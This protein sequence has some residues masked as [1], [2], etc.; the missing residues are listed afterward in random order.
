MKVLI[1]IL[2]AAG[3]SA[4]GTYIY[5]SNQKAGQFR[6]EL[7]EQQARWKS[8]KDRFETDLKRA[9]TRSGRVETVE[10]RV[11]A[12]TASRG[13]GSAQE[14]IEKLIAIRPGAEGNRNH[15]L[16]QIVYNLESLVEM[17][18]PALPAIRNFL[19]KNQDVEYER[20][21]N[22]GEN[23]AQT[24][25]VTT[26]GPPS[27]GAPAPQSQGASRSGGPNA[28]PRLDF[29]YP[30]S[31]RLGLFNVLGQIRGVDAEQ[32][33]ADVLGTTGRGM[34]LATVAR[35]LEELAPGK[36]K[37][38][39]LQGAKE[40]LTNPPAVDHPTRLDDLSK[41]YLYA[42]LMLYN[43]SSF[44][45]TAQTLLVTPEGRLDRTPLNYLTGVLKDQAVPILYQEYKNSRLTNSTD[46]MN[47]IASTFTY[48]GINPQANDV[49]KEVVMSAVNNLAVSAQKQ[50]PGGGASA[51]TGA[52]ANDS[53]IP[54]MAIARMD[55]GDLNEPEIRSRQQLLMSLKSGIKD[56]KINALID[57]TVQS[58]Q[59]KLT[60]AGARR[61]GSSGTP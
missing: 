58:L 32:A 13:S 28:L 2:V 45:S 19:A 12:P 24:G 16:R 1:S 35:L 3:I 50:S 36:Y 60:T 21:A 52:R 42:V 9:K 40:L 51:S 54:L 61:S 57:R 17:G 44:A 31:L 26:G 6:K 48:V 10:A 20:G 43:D 53:F 41:G 55:T 59:Q 30:P 47:L 27:P 39:A 7:E 37:G 25:P 34:E 14:I 11:E 23:Q 29:L 22:P 33:L 56:E 38:S 8:E 4:G 5:V 46:R 49:F 15:A 18:S